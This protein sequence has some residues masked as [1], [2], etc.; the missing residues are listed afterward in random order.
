[1]YK[2]SQIIRSM[3]TSKGK[4]IAIEYVTKTD[5]WERMML[6]PNTQNEFAVVAEKYKDKLKPDTVKVAMK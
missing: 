2:S 5:A 3:T 4:R 1:M 6:S